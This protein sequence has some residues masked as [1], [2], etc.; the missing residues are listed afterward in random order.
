[1]NLVGSFLIFIAIVLSLLT[2]I[3]LIGWWRGGENVLFPGLGLVVTIPAIIV[4]L[5]IL[6]IVFVITAA[7][8]KP[9]Q[10]SVSETRFEQNFE[11][12]D[13]IFGG[14]G[15]GVLDLSVAKNP[16]KWGQDVADRQLKVCI[17]FV[18]VESIHDVV[19]PNR[20]KFCEYKE[21]EDYQKFVENNRK[22]L[23]Q[24]FFE[25]P[26]LGKID[27]MYADFV[28][29]SEEAKKLRVE[30]LKLQATKLNTAADLAL[31][32]LIYAC[33]EALKENSYL[34]FSGD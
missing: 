5:L 12:P 33:D 25:Y 7:I 13:D 32:K 31:R 22:I 1:M 23:E 8:I 24:A 11:Y 15:N 17:N 3:A 2:F 6:N 10:E 21:G 4:L 27:D 19:A 20:V 29:N 30:C 18:D 9:R 16:Q 28:F 34:I 14:C 26:M